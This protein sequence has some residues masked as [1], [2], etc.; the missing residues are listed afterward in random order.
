MC[1]SDFKLNLENLQLFAYYSINISFLN[2]DFPRDIKDQL[3]FMEKIESE[4]RR[5]KLL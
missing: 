4:V 5:A 3:K 1:P 2:S